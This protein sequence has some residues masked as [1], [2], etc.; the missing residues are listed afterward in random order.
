MF[1]VQ[2]PEVVYVVFVSVCTSVC[3]VG[4]YTNICYTFVFRFYDSYGND[5]AASE[6]EA[7]LF[8]T[9]LSNEVSDKSCSTCISIIVFV[10]CVNSRR[11]ERTLHSIIV[12]GRTSHQCRLQ[13]ICM[14]QSF[15]CNLVSDPQQ[16]LLF[17]KASNY[18]TFL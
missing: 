11:L 4:L 13:C 2:F 5:T 14:V 8:I 6:L 1:S 7:E 15:L 3:L 17:T 10:S 18:Y 12:S 9:L 16:Q